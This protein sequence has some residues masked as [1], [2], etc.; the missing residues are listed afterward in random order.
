MRLLPQTV[1][2]RTRDAF[3]YYAKW[4]HELKEL[5]PEANHMVVRGDYRTIL[6]D[7]AVPMGVVYADP[8]YTRDH[9]SR[10]YHVLETMA[11]H[12]NPPISTT[13]IRSRESRLSRGMY[14]TGRHQSPFSIVSEAPSAFEALAALSSARGVPLLL[15]YSPFYGSSRPRVIELDDLLSILRGHFSDVRSSWIPGSVHSKLNA[16]ARNVA[17]LHDAEVLVTCLPR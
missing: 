11:R 13:K 5:S 15:S 14:R 1:R 7:P 16:S 2:D 4:L 9:Y 8:P 12:D 3:A 10:Y 17:V 6:A